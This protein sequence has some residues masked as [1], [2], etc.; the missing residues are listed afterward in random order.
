MA[1]VAEQDELGAGA[2]DIGTELVEGAAADHRRLVEDD[3][4]ATGEATA[5][6]QIG[7]ELGE[8]RTGDA[9]TRLEVGGRPCRHRRADDPEAGLLPADPGGTEKRRLARSRLA[10]HQVVAVARGE[11]RP[12]TVGLLAVEVGV[13]PE[14]V[15]DRGWGRPG[16][17]LRRCLRQRNR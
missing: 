2:I 12:H 11:Q 9:R 16:R 13:Q 17:F 8:R 1:V 5:F 14:D 15:F 6:P 10:D 3:H 7:Q 4:V